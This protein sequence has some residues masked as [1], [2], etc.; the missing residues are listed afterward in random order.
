MPLK[1]A[2]SLREPFDFPQPGGQMSP[3]CH[4]LFPSSFSPIDGCL[5]INFSLSLS[6]PGVV[7]GLFA[8]SLPGCLRYATDQ[9]SEINETCGHA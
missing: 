8:G 4:G 3:W 6:Q 9:V 5:I 1:R 2:P 7:L